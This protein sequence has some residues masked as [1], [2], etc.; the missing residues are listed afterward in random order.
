M[1][2]LQFMGASDALEGYLNG[3]DDGYVFQGR[4]SG[5]ISTRQIQRLLDTV[6]E[7]A[8]LQ[9]IRTGKVRYRKRIT[10]HLLRHSFSR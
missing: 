1:Y 6:A 8:G 2:N 4:D 9:E 3:R 5:H 10:P 7:R